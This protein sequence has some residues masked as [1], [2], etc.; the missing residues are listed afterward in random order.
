MMSAKL[1][2]KDNFLVGVISDTHGL[3]RPGIAKI[4]NGTDLIIH[5]G[6]VDRPNILEAL[7]EIAPVTAVRGNMDYGE[8][9][10]KLPVTEIIE[11][12]NVCLYMF[13]NP[14][15]LDLDPGAAGFAAV[16]NG[17]THNPF[18]EKKN[19]V[20]FLNPGSAGPKRGDY[21]VT[22]SLLHIRGSDLDAQIIQMDE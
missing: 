1:K 13:H 12:G 19:G 22:V 14:Y 6:D 8:W 4:F 5:A 21:P 15:Q 3:L 20:L 11:I 7:R 10:N 16:I 17:H 2:N 9:A 18:V